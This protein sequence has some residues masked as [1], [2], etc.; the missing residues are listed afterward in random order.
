MPFKNHQLKLKRVN[1]SQ[2]LSDQGGKCLFCPT[3]LFKATGNERE[4]KG[5]LKACTM[6]HLTPTWRGGAEY[7]RSNLAAMCTDCNSDKGG[8]TLLEYQYFKTKPLW[9][10]EEARNYLN[11]LAQQQYFYGDVDLSQVDLFTMPALEYHCEIW[12]ESRKVFKA[13]LDKKRNASKYIWNQTVDYAASLGANWTDCKTWIK[14]RTLS[15][16]PAENLSIAQR[17]VAY[18]ENGL[19]ENGI[20]VGGD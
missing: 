13:E 10:L 18:F 3:T 12:A 15:K 5:G 14:D 2:I 7:D 8:M 20:M 17:V 16:V 11:R 4:R 19:A 9:M 6:D 1:T